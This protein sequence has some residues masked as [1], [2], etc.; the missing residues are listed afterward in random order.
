MD[1]LA[2]T[3]CCLAGQEVLK[4]SAQSSCDHTMAI[5]S[6]F[7]DFLVKNQLRTIHLLHWALALAFLLFSSS[8]TIFWEGTLEQQHM[9]HIVQVLFAWYERGE[10]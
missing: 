4:M 10:L 6:D 8:S 5:I 2:A 3:I 7:C 1:H 9:D